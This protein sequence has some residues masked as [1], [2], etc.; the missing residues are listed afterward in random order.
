M[1]LKRPHVATLDEVTITRNGED[2]I[3]E[4]A[5][6]GSGRRIFGWDLRCSR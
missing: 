5:T 2:A 1:R 3:I 4:Y 6:S